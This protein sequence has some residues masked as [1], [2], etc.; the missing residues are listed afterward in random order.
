MNATTTTTTTAKKMTSGVKP[1][2]VLLGI[3]V[4]QEQFVVISEPRAEEERL[5][6]EQL[7]GKLHRSLDGLRRAATTGA[8]HPKRE[9]RPTLALAPLR[10]QLQLPKIRRGSA[11]SCRLSFAS[12]KEHRE[13]GDGD[14]QMVLVQPVSSPARSHAP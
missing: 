4:Q 12:Y 6:H 13:H 3:R 2:R 8:I 10:L 9:H 5:L 1:S 14:V 7:D 11:T